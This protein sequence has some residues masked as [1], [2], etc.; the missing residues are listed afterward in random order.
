MPCGPGSNGS[1][2]SEDCDETAPASYNARGRGRYASCLSILGAGIERDSFKCCCLTSSIL[3]T[4]YDDKDPYVYAYS[5]STG[6]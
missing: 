6:S 1:P 2:D 5:P 4:N 3:Y